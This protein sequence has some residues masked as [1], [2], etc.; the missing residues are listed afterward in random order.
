MDDLKLFP[1]GP[2]LPTPFFL[3]DVHS[4]RLQLPFL[5]YITDNAHP[6]V[7]CL[8]LP[9]ATHF[10]QVG[11]SKQ[12]NGRCKKEIV[13]AKRNI[14]RQRMHLGESAKI[15][16]FDII[17]CVSQAFPVS[18]GDVDGNRKA[19]YERGWNPLNR[20]ILLSSKLTK[21]VEL[22]SSDSEVE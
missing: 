4:S 20:N 3:C 1:R 17:P 14:I 18:F 21:I 13:L 11:D 9:N 22:D 12:Q 19:I 6:W 8:G 7:V 10:W 2:G 15:E 16:T 5:E